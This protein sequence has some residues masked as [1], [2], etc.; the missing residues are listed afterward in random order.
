MR[1][2]TTCCG[3]KCWLMATS[4][5]RLSGSS[6]FPSTATRSQTWRLAN[7]DAHA[8]TEGGKDEEDNGEEE[9]GGEDKG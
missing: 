4:R 9:D 8:V 5:R 2:R 3:Q 1:Y 7:G 6:R